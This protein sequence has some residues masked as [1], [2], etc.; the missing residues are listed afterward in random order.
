M[1]KYATKTHGQVKALF[2]IARQC[3][4]DDDQLHDVVEDVTKRT[5]SIKELTHSEADRVIARLKGKNNVPLRTLQY[6][7]RKAGVEQIVQETQ[8][9]LI[10]QLA[11][12]RNWSSETLVNF[13]RKMV[14][15]A[16]PATTSEANKIIE[17]LKAMNRRDDL[18][19][20]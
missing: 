12:Q 10:A 6:R 11:S 7:R 18:W 19:A 1:G 5:R 2:G 4:L 13:C 16:K 14:K 3:G 17:A 9:Q 15:R 8:L 20:A